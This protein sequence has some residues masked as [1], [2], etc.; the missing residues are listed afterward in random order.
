MNDKEREARGQKRLRFTAGMHVVDNGLYYVVAFGYGR[1]RELQINR[2]NGQFS[3]TGWITAANA[4]QA[5]DALEA[6]DKALHG[7]VR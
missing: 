1:S 3:K 6:L 5:L 2:V 4:R 7:E